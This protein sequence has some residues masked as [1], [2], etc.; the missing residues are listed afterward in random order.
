[1]KTL[2]KK[3]LFWDVAEV[4][5]KKNKKFIIERILNFGDEEDF[6]W[7]IKIYGNNEVKENLL[8][9]RTLDKK[10]LYFW[11]QYF[12]LDQSQCL[13]DQSTEKPSWFSK[14]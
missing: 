13:K 3:S 11:R 14:R 4:N 7:A 12:N 10:S 5:P 1:M 6:R 2:E 8:K 9:S